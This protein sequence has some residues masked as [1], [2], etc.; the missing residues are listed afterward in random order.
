MLPSARRF[1]VRPCGATKR[2]AP[3]CRSLLFSHISRVHSFS[4]RP[5]PALASMGA[6]TPPAE[7]LRAMMSLGQA[8]GVCEPTVVTVRRGC[9]PVG[10][11]ARVAQVGFGGD[12]LREGACWSHWVRESATFIRRSRCVHSTSHAAGR[13]ADACANK[14]QHSYGHDR[15]R[16]HWIARVAISTSL[17]P[18]RRP[19]ASL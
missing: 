8:P 5:D 4:R 19:K 1:Q 14:A 3:P 15:T 17:N 11:A 10:M 2:E 12:A 16:E 13:G 7:A 18:V 6:E 9:G